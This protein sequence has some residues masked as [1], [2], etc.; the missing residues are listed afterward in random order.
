MK[1]HVIN[2]GV[3]NIGSVL[4]IIEKVGGSAE[5]VSTPS[6]ILEAEKIILPG[7]GHFDHAISELKERGLLE[8]LQEKI[9]KQKVPILGICLGMQLLC[10]RSEEG[11]MPGLGLVDAVVR[12]FPSST[13]L[14]IKIPHMGWNNVAT[15]RINPLTDF[16][17][18][19]QRFY[20]VHSYYVEPE[21]SDLTIMTAIHGIEFCA[22]FQS[23]NILGVQFHP[24]KSHRFG[25]DL[26]AHFIRI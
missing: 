23:G 25:M 8:A 18:G 14:K 10:R 11:T 22:A 19:Q 24:E 21:V 12:K 13:S 1:V 6:G 7:V 3:G 26:M 16:G 4:R 17:S 9:V 15:S 5:S 20:F 2:Y